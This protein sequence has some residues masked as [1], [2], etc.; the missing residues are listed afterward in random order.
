MVKQRHVI[1]SPGMTRQT[2]LITSINA[3]LMTR[4]HSK[5]RVNASLSV[6]REMKDGKTLR[7]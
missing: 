1:N 3:A 5:K 2:A 7:L 6:D 4:E